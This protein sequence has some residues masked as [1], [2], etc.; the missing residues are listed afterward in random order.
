[1]VPVTVNVI[2]PVGHVSAKRGRIEIPIHQGN[3]LTNP[4][5]EVNYLRI[6]VECSAA[7]VGFGITDG[8][9][10]QPHQ[11]P[12]LVGVTRYPDS[13]KNLGIVIKGRQVW[14]TRNEISAGRDG[15]VHRVVNGYG[16]AKISHQISNEAPIII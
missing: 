4:E 13:S 5:A 8:V 11:Y 12:P 1:V 15:R 2:H 6:E 14:T 10:P 7:A 9:S 3:E 16:C